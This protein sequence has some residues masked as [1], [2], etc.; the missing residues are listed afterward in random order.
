[1]QGTGYSN[2]RDVD[3]FGNGGNP[4]RM[5]NTD[6]A[7]LEGFGS[8]YK[9]EGRR[10][11]EVRPTSPAS[12]S[13]RVEYTTGDGWEQ[14]GTESGRGSVTTGRA[15][16]GL[17]D[18]NEQ[19]RHGSWDGRSTGR[20]EFANDRAIEQRTG[21][22]NGYWSNADWLLC[23]DGKWRPVEPGTF[24]LVNGAPARVGRLRAYGN[25]INAEAAE[26]VIRAYMECRP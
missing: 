12:E 6:D 21:P 1:M 16:S 22:V 19:Q 17:A 15:L 3:R 13:C 9:T 25:A 24:P 8:G 10:V 5:D 7:G 20:G 14:R 2:G 18:S 23:R 4:D 11:G 26:A